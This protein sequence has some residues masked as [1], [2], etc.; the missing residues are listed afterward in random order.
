MRKKVETEMAKARVR[1]EKGLVP[2]G[3]NVTRHLALP[4]KGHTTEWI[5]EEMDKM[6]NE[7]HRSDWK[8]G[9]VSGAVYRKCT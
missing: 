5:F 9:K 3:E 2:E 7:I 6:D 4:T 8:Q 1:I